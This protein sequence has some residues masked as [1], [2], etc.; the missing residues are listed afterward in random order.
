MDVDLMTI[1]TLQI[2]GSSLSHHAHIFDF[3]IQ[4]SYPA[5]EPVSVLRANSLI[6]LLVSGVTL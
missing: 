5:L 6:K 2:Y 4:P 1:P 3:W